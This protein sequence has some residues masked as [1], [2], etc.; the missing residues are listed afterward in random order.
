MGYGL[1]DRAS[2][3]ARDREGII[4]PHHHVQ[5]GSG[6]YSFPMGTEAS[7]PGGKAAGA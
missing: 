7:F 4:S 3:P 6:F 5:I 1:D 2:I